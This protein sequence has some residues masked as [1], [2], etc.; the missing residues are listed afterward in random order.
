MLNHYK[1]LGA[2]ETAQVLFDLLDEA[3]NVENEK[4][5]ASLVL[6]VAEAL[7]D[8]EM[9]EVNYTYSANHWLYMDC[10]PA[11]EVVYHFEDFVVKLESGEME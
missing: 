2:K 8:L 7:D 3:A 10:L 9:S 1:L 11:Q 5:K 6:E 4:L